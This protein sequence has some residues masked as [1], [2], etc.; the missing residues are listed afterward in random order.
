VTAVPTPE[1]SRFDPA[2]GRAAALSRWAM[3]PDRTA[4]TRKA[5]EGFLRRF[6]RL[7]D[8]DGTM[9]DHERHERA[10]RL[11][12]AHMIRLARKRRRRRT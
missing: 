12:R 8:P 5:R 4:A 7:V 1:P 11:M 10:E 2:T 6:E 9:P 3:E